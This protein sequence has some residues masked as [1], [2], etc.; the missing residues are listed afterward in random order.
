MTTLGPGQFT[1]ELQLLS[2]RRNLS[3]ARVVRPGAVIELDRESLRSLVQTDGELS[4]LLMRAFIL[5]RLSLIE[6]GWGDVVLL[7]SRHSAGTLRVKEFLV[8]NGH[9]YEYVELEHDARVQALLDRF[10]VG[11]GDVPVLICQ[12]KAVLRNPT[13]EEVAVCLGFNE[14]IDSALIRDVIVVGAGPAGLAAAVYAASEGLSVMVIELDAPGGQSGASSRIENYLGFPTGVSGQELAARAYTQAQKFGADVMIARRAV[15]LLCDRRPYAV[16]LEDGARVSAR[17]V[18]VATGAQY[19]RL[20]L[21]NLSRFEGNGVYYSATFMEAQLCVQEDVVIVGGANS[22]GQAAVFL[23]ETARKVHLLVRSGQLAD[24]MSRY[25]VR[26]IEENPAIELHVRTELVALE[27]DN[28]LERVRWRSNDTGAIEEHAIRHVFVMTGAAPNT[29]WLDGCVAFD[30]RGF[31][32]TGQDLH[33]EDL[34][35]SEWPLARPPFLLETSRPG[36]FAVGDVR[37]GN[38]KRVASAVGEGSISIALVHK[39]LHE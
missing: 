14:T 30:E 11:V 16:E 7:G 22:A 8:R 34:A 23:A 2:G 25:L 5:R 19:R 29:H 33:A 32:R 12:D 6:A 27:G 4:E 21:E 9:P 31:V 17:A 20:P 10:H 1:G 35:A 37:A 28:Q 36:V 15:R 18:I 39:V 3:R 26:R 13:N 38:V 24:A